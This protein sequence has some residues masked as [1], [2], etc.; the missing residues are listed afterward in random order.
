MALTKD[1][2]QQVIDDVEKLLASSKLT[3][4]ARYSG[5]SVEAM[6]G[7]RTQAGDNGT[8][9]K[10]VKNRLFKKALENLEGYKGIDVSVFNGQLLYAFNEDDEVAPAQ[11]L[12]AFAKTQPQIEF[13][14]GLTADG[15]ILN[16]DDLKALA[17]LPTKD[18]L[19][20]QAIG[21]IS[22]P[23]TGFVNVLSANVRSVLNVLNA[24]AEQQT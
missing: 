12:A 23:A 5:T 4:A 8:R 2:K 14:A 15:Q 20:A 7:L 18:Q 21:V 17:A 13:V 3:V 6:Q 1:K 19:R 22:A 9:V 11:S 10:V 24:R 16:A